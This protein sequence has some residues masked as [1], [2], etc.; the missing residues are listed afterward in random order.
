MAAERVSAISSASSSS[1]AARRVIRERECHVGSVRGQ[2]VRGPGDGQRLRMVAQARE[3]V[4]HIDRD[5]GVIRR[6][7]VRRLVRAKRVG[8][9]AVEIVRVGERGQDIRAPRR[10]RRTVGEM[11]DRLLVVRQRDTRAAEA[12]QDVGIVGSRLKAGAQ[13]AR[14]VLETAPHQRHNGEPVACVAVCGVVA[15]DGRVG[16]VGGVHAARTRQTLRFSEFFLQ[17]FHGDEDGPV[18][19]VTVKRGSCGTA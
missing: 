7:F 5:A 18:W 1:P 16:A 13:F 2:R 4:G 19:A 15:K 3:S 9:V 12:E 8:H 11:D 17:R 6:E 10:A 14:A